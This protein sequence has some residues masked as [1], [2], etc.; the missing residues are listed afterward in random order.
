MK[1]D[2]FEIYKQMVHEKYKHY[3]M[4]KWLAIIFMAISVCLV[5]LLIA[6]GCIFNETHTINNNDVEIVNEGE[7][8][9]NNVVLNN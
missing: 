5:V 8:N 1:K 4:W 9:T 3:A 7:G 6:N 2:E